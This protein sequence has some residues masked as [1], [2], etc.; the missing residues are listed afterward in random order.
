MMFCFI[1]VA[2]LFSHPAA[3][4][5]F[6]PKSS[7]VYSKNQKHG[8][9]IHIPSLDANPTNLFDNHHFY[10]SSSDL[11]SNHISGG[12]ASTSEHRLPHYLMSSATPAKE[13]ADIR[14]G[15]STVAK[16]A[17]NKKQLYREMFAEMLGTFI[18]VGLGSM[19]DMSAIFTGSL[20]GLFQIASVWAI[21]VTVAICTTAS[22][23]DAHLN[24]GISIAFAMFRPSEKF[25][26]SKVVP[27][28]LAQLAGASLGS[29]MAFRMY[30]STIA[31]FEAKQGIVR[32]A[33]SGLASVKAFGCYFA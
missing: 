21:A 8:I 2:F 13:K 33:T 14:G 31:A 5:A 3:S 10:D 17:S 26:W 7:I 29:L 1:V 18:I 12:H 25:G 27:Y 19:G 20:V 4:D 16:P 15:E 30:A 28:C 11:P 32:A 9:H 23:S 6:A 22:I 24:P